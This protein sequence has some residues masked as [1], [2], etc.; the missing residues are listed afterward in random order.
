[1]FFFQDLTE[2]EIFRREWTV[3]VSKYCFNNFIEFAQD[4]YASHVLRRL[5]ECLSGRE[6]STD[7][8]KSKRSQNQAQAKLDLTKISKETSIFKSNDSEIEGI[9]A[10]VCQKIQD[11][12]PEEFKDLC[13][14]EVSSEVLQ[15]LLLILDSKL[16]KKL[17]K[18]ITNEMFAEA[19]MDMFQRNALTRLM[20]VLIQVSG[21][22]NDLFKIY[23]HFHQVI[24]KTH[25]SEFSMHSQANYSV[26]KII[27]H[28]PKKEVFE[29]MFEQELDDMIGQ[30]VKSACNPG[31]LLSIGQACR[32]LA[33]KQAHFLAALNKAFNCLEKNQDKFFIYLITFQTR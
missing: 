31:V 24:F 17:S 14:N 27:Q 28:C 4:P 19:N 32:K 13:L 10:L 21:D 1:M 15:T 18:K 20:E 22:N 25:L 7:L 33:S 5:L 2:F 6:L 8:L 12:S 26:Q 9:F 30:L 3:K 16:A 11:A 29:D 23:N